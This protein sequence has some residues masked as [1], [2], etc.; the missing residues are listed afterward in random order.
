MYVLKTPCPYAEIVWL[1][2]CPIYFKVCFGL[3]G[4]LNGNKQNELLQ[5]APDRRIRWKRGRV[6]V[7]GAERL[8]YYSICQRTVWKHR[9]YI[10]SNDDGCIHLSERATPVI[11]GKAGGYFSSSPTL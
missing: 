8:C 10:F 3:W 1:F 7:A 5:V 11:T 4:T 2:L 6:A 9:H